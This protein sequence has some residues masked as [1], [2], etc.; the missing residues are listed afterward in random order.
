MSATKPRSGGSDFYPQLDPVSAAARTLD[1]L[2][3][4]AGQ[5]A[6]SVASRNQ[7]RSVDL[8]HQMDT[9]ADILDALSIPGA[10]SDLAKLRRHI[11]FP[12]RYAPTGQWDKIE[13]DPSDCLTDLAG[14]ESKL[15]EVA[16]IDEPWWA[17]V[18]PSVR[19]VAESR[20]AAGHLADAVEAALK[21]VNSRVKREYKERTRVELDGKGLMMK[22]FSVDKP[23]IV[24]ADLDTDSG[25]S[26]QE[27]YMFLFAGAMEALRNP[28]AHANIDIDESRA[29]HHL[30]VASLLMSKL[31]DAGVPA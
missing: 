21:E 26:E 19:R 17:N 29:L 27:G 8:C 5:L 25:K 20:F 7:A 23:Q 6:S 2:R 13:S 11:R 22:A 14:L 16:P 30:F 3:L 4:L 1:R 15:A 12:A 9:L 10:A 24:L 18:H 28:K 31:D